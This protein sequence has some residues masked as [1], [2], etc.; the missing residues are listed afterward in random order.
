MLPTELEREIFE[1]TALLFPSSIPALLLVARRVHIWLEP[2]LYRVLHTD[3]APSATVI[4]QIMKTKPH[5]LRD[6]VRHVYLEPFTG[7]RGWRV[8]DYYALLALCS[9]LVSFATTVSFS[10][11]R[12]I[13]LLEGLPNLRNVNAALGVYRFPRGHPAL[14][15]LRYLHIFDI[16]SEADEDVPAL[17]A[18]LP[19]LTHL[20][21]NTASPIV[22]QRAL[23]ECI[24]LRVLLNLVLM[25]TH[26]TEVHDKR[27]VVMAFPSSYRNEWLAAARGRDNFWTRAEEFVCKKLNGEI[28]SSC[29]L[30]EHQPTD[31]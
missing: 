13:F 24:N 22:A 8:E 12:L 10:A 11:P 28:P 9:N 20:A 7:T 5:L 30:L 14:R 19:Q 4:R 6:G 27:Y 2:M 21:L 15:G 1:T 29:Y 16:I 17:F 18:E 25:L 3:Q 31:S 26:A 23:C